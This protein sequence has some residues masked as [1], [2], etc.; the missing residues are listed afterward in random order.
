MIHEWELIPISHKFAY[1]RVTA[2]LSGGVIDG[3]SEYI[4][5]RALILS[6][7]E[8]NVATNILK[9]L[10]NFPGWYRYGMQTLTNLLSIFRLECISCTQY[11]RG[12]APTLAVMSSNSQFSQSSLLSVFAT[13][14]ILIRNRFGPHVNAILNLLVLSRFN[15]LMQYSTC[16]CFQDLILLPWYHYHW[17]ACSQLNLNSLLTKYTH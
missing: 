12:R 11:D 14:F 15:M 1:L 6:S 9:Y 17:V 3:R 7:M 16:W 2:N 4:V 13:R 10:K 8:S 5:M